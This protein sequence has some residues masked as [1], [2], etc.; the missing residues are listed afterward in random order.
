MATQAQRLVSR[1]AGPAAETAAVEKR[2]AP[3][4]PALSRAAESIWVAAQ[5]STWSSLA[6]V[7][8]EPGISVGP[9]AAALAAVGGAQRGEAVQYL[10]LRGVAFSDSRPAAETLADRTAPARLVAALDCPLESQAA[11]LLASAAS[12]CVLVVAK[13]RT[14]LAQARRIVESLGRQRLLGAVI[15]DPAA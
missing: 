3:A 11:Q 10:D 14:D 8:A 7:P 6:L 4:D 15:I 9:I 13:D 5:R 12:L 1:T 2:A